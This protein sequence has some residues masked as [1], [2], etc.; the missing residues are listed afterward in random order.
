MDYS[1]LM[2]LGRGL[3]NFGAS[4]GQSITERQRREAEKA[5]RAQRDRAFDNLL[6]Q[7]ALSNNLEEDT[8]E[9]DQ[10]ISQ[11]VTE[12]FNAGRA[13]SAELGMVTPPAPAPVYRDSYPAN[14]RESAG[15]DEPIAPLSQG[16]TVTPLSALTAEPLTQMANDAQQRLQSF[17]TSP[18]TS[19]FRD[20]RSRRVTLTDSQGRV[21]TYIQPYERT[22]EGRAETERTRVAG[23]RTTTVERLVAAGYDKAQAELLADAGPAKIAEAILE[24]VNP[25]SQRLQFDP[26]TARVIDLETGTSKPVQ[27]V[28]P[29]PRPTG[30]TSSDT[31]NQ[32]TFQRESSLAAEY[33]RNP[34]VQDA[35]AQA[36]AAIQIQ[37]L[38]RNVD[39]P[40]GDLDIIY[41]VVKLRDPGSVVREGE[42]DLQR[43]AR[44][45]GTQIATLWNK[46]KSGRMLTAQERAQIV[47]LVDTKLDAVQQRVSPVMRDF[48]ARSR[49]WGADSSFVAPNPLAGARGAS[50]N[51]YR[52][53]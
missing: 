24:S 40:Q 29:R 49:E 42:I 13:P 18:Q 12:S 36:N 14:I 9:R 37:A 6:S 5:E 45:L 4:W 26:E 41:Q 19:G 31:A 17:D 51:P 53:R 2:G 28:R 43:A 39:N 15:F 1:T 44:S 47:A 52:S 30:G 8:G 16:G 33:Q 21:R 25:T 22:T 32:R 48:G 35:Y 46:A 20:P 11:S 50:T 38:A 23:E 3:E 10:L 27:G 7:F 34:I